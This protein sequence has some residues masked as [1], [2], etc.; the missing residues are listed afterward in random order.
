MVD[1]AITRAQSVDYQQ[2]RVKQL[3]AISDA[4]LLDVIQ[5]A[6]GRVA[7]H[8]TKVGEYFQPYL[9]AQAVPGFGMVQLL[10]L[11]P[12]ARRKGLSWSVLNRLDGITDLRQ[13][14]D[15]LLR[16]AQGSAEAL[17]ELPQ[18][19]RASRWVSLGPEVTWPWFAQHQNVLLAWLGGDAGDVT[20]ALQV[21][22][23]FPVIPAPLQS[24]VAAAALGDSRKARPVAQALLA[25]HGAARELAE[26]GLADAKGE[27]RAAS[28][29][30]LA[31]LGDP[32]AIPTLRTALAKEKREVP[33]A[34]F[35]AALQQLGDDISSDL[36][37]GPLLAEARAGLRA[38][39]PPALGWFGF[40]QLPTLQWTDGTPV[41]PQLPRWWVVLA[42][43]VKDP[44]GSG[45][46]DLYLGRL[47]PDAA[48]ALGRFVLTSWVAQDVRHPSEEESRAH[49]PTEGQ[50]RH[51]SAQDLL[52]R[53]RGNERVTWVQQ[54]AAIPVEQHV[55]EV[56]AEHQ[57]L[58][59][60]SAAANR[61]L[62]ALTTRMPG[63]ELAN[64]VQAYIRNHGARRAQVD[65]LMHTLFANGQPAAVQLLLSV[66][67]RFKQASVQATAAR[68]VEALAEQRGWTPEE[69]ADRTIPTAGF[70]ADALL[71]LDFGSR[72]FIGRA[73]PLGTIEL[74]TAEGATIKSLPGARAAD[75]KELVAGAKKQLTT[76]RKE[77]KAVL[78]Q[79]TARLYEAMCAGRTWT[80]S[81]W[82][83]FLLGHPL[84]GQLA[85][86]LVW[87][88]DPGLQ[89]QPFRPTEDGGLIDTDDE[90][91]ELPDDSQ[92]VLA[93]RV[94]VG[95]AAS[96]EWLQHLADYEVPP[97]FEQFGN[98]LPAIDRTA[99]QLT[100]LKGHLTD[101][102]SFRGLAGKRGYQRGAAEDGAWFVEY[103]KPFASAGLTAV[104]EFTGSYLPEEN[105]TC[106]TV[107]LSFRG[108]RNRPVALSA[109]P[110]VLLAECYADYAALAALGPFD[111]EW[112]K[113]AGL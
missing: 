112:E 32:A 42:N 11:G 36:G 82:R 40:D 33:R 71:R 104:Q 18:L 70:D 61:G 35:L 75:D 93:H 72:E 53:Y 101:T 41:D 55:R 26:Q 48:A 56:F 84:V 96:A 24:S 108:P 39:L 19:G 6:N 111:P 17:A 67:R 51:T 77:L 37:P 92:V 14:E 21:L 107:G 54:R 46:F 98:P 78:T 63:I 91:V 49:A 30:W 10:R 4:D 89:Q 97:L 88:A 5:V 86:R 102:F 58:Y 74:S 94:S 12:D 68:L 76:S 95:D 15:A 110:D 29:Q 44:D 73:T 66:S 13:V 16:T 1:T 31:T 109:V 87:I 85:S 83:E 25:R 90:L 20:D 9:I 50:R 38:K 57:S 23:G 60:G 7:A 113:K 106:A 45:L 65:A 59:L 22:D 80:A 28:A 27:L 43:K 105:L 64:A 103:T 47:Q 79:Q 69:L 8:Q 34:A 3:R 99:T 81:D 100:D 2:R 62:L 52:R